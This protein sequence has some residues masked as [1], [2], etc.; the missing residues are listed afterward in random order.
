MEVEQVNKKCID[1]VHAPEL[2]LLLLVFAIPSVLSS[3]KPPI[4]TQRY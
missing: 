3:R 1:H 4:K 2:V